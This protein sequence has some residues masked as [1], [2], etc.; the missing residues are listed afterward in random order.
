MT[1]FDTIMSCVCDCDLDRLVVHVSSGIVHA[2]VG[3]CTQFNV[4]VYVRVLV[5]VHRPEKWKTLGFCIL[6]E[7]ILRGC[8]LKK[9]A[10]FFV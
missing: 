1:K 8:Q 7:M 4:H 2:S 9:S 10:T 5:L 3:V 6:L